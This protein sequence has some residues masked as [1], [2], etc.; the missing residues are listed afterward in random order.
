MLEHSFHP[1]MFLQFLPYT[2][3]EDKYVIELDD[4]KFLYLTILEVPLIIVFITL[5]ASSF[6]F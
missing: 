5:K 6:F 4:T 2:P 3:P 1:C